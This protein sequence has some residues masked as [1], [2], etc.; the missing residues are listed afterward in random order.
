MLPEHPSPI[1]PAREAFTFVK[2]IHDAVEERFK[3][4]HDL[5][6]IDANEQLHPGELKIDLSVVVPVQKNVFYDT[7]DRKY[8]PELVKKDIPATQAE[9]MGLLGTFPVAEQAGLLNSLKIEMGERFAPSWTREIPADVVERQEQLSQ[10]ITFESGGRQAR[11]FNFT[12]TQLSAEDTGKVAN[13]LREMCD[14]TGGAVMGM[15]DAMVVLPNDDPLISPRNNDGECIGN[16]SGLAD[17]GKVFFAEGLFNPDAPFPVVTAPEADYDILDQDVPKHVE[18]DQIQLT[19]FHELTHV[20]AGD[21]NNDDPTATAN[22]A[23]AVG[24]EFDQGRKSKVKRRGLVENPVAYGRVDQHED[25][26]VTGEAEFAGGEWFKKV[27]DVRRFALAAIWA[28]RHS[29][30]EGPAFV[31]AT[32]LPLPV[33]PN[34]LDQATIPPLAVR[35]SYNYF[36]E[37]LDD[38]FGFSDY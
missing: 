19:V 33:Y 3:D 2:D 23:K 28:K 15:L 10:I 25:I 24:W 16:N 31:R 21:G 29:Q 4:G 37:D 35:P 1:V 20:V 27:D 36:A 30:V 11:L 18:G 17:G 22:F 14:R 12:S 6:I 5:R 26:T 8:P 9:E 32:E 7:L 38:P 34:K 13:S